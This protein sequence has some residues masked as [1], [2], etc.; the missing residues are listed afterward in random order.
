MKLQS[1]QENYH[2]RIKMY[3]EKINGP[4]DVKKLSVEEM[5]QL[6]EEMR[7]AL[8]TRASIHEIGRASCRERV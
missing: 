6:A 4:E 7:T 8:L 2:G 5:T 1:K 3:I